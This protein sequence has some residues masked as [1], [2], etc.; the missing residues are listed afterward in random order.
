MGG[1]HL[2]MSGMAMEVA[3]SRLEMSSR[4]TDW[5][6]STE[7]ATDVFSPPGDARFSCTFRPQ[8]YRVCHKPLLTTLWC[9]DKYL[10][11]QP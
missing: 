1:T 7:M 6:S 3:G 11:P 4:K 8:V 5:A 2:P 10:R 9:P